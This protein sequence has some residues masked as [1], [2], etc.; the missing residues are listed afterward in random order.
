MNALSVDAEARDTVPSVSMV[1]G[2]IAPIEQVRFR[3]WKY[4]AY[5]E[6]RIGK[7]AGVN[8]GNLQWP[9]HSTVKDG[10]FTGITE[11][12]RS[13]DDHH[14]IARIWNGCEKTWYPRFGT[15]NSKNLNAEQCVG[16]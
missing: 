14:G 2:S 5:Q 16:V 13:R 12:P 11:T 6:T 7:P 10:D 1:Y 15:A 4:L 9:G 8:I 3:T